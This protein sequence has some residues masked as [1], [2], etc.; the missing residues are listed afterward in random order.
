MNRRRAGALGEAVG[1]R[2]VKPWDS[3]VNNSAAGLQ[4]IADQIN[5]R[6][7]KNLEQPIIHRISKINNKDSQKS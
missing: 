5:S 2:F 3:F 7:Y 6:L 4:N 1:D